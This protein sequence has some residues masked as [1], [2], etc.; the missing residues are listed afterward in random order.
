MIAD[1][2]KSQ[3]PHGSSKVSGKCSYKPDVHKST[4][5]LSG[6][7]SEKEKNKTQNESFES[8]SH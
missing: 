7:P 4:Y 5:T 2:Q 6:K 3:M 8:C 1:G